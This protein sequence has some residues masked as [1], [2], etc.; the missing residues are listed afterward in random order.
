MDVT[1]DTEYERGPDTYYWHLT[2]G[3]WISRDLSSN[4][5]YG[6]AD[7]TFRHLPYAVSYRIYTE[8][9]DHRYRYEGVALS[10]GLLH[11]GI[12]MIAT[13][14]LTLGQG[15]VTAPDLAAMDALVLAQAK[16]RDAR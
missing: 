8:G 13:D 1:I 15:R 4:K 7:A 12:E 3:L 6:Y 5:P 11:S 14:L 16:L 2:N 10:F 9:G